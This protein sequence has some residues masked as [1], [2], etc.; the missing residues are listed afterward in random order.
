[1]TAE[2]DGRDVVVGRVSGLEMGRKTLYRAGT[3]LH[4]SG[5][6]GSACRVMSVRALTVLL[7]PLACHARNGSG[8]AAKPPPTTSTGY[9]R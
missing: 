6:D 9:T 1:M 2:R 8:V 4:D 7:R 3:G 5:S